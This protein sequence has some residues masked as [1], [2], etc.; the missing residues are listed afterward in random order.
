MADEGWDDDEFGLFE[1]ADAST[2]T[3]AP[4]ITSAQPVTPAWLLAAQH[5]VSGCGSC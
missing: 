4:V 3:N 1:S 5:H 2:I